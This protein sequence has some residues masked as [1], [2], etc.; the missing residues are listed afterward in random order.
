[1]LTS[2]ER[3]VGADPHLAFPTNIAT[4]AARWGNT[5]LVDPWF[6]LIPH[7][8]TLAVG[9][10]AAGVSV[11]LGPCCSSE[12]GCPT[13][14]LMAQSRT[15]LENPV[16]ITTPSSANRPRCVLCAIAVTKLLA[17]AFRARILPP[18]DP[19]R[20]LYVFA[21]GAHTLPCPP[22]S[23]NGGPHINSQN[24]FTNCGVRA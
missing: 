3:P 18:A 21:A 23:V 12:G 4:I 2:T 5:R 8:A 22:L 1:M 6:R 15:H 13:P 14:L 9:G 11:A 10:P 24:A 19:R 7:P 16:S 17:L 20:S